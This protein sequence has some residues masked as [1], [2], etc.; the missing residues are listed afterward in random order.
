MKLKNTFLALVVAFAVAAPL[1][2]CTGYMNPYARG[3]PQPVGDGYN[4]WPDPD[5]YTP[6]PTPT[7]VQRGSSSSV[8]GTWDVIDM[9]MDNFSLGE[10]VEW[11]DSCTMEFSSNGSLEMRAELFGYSDSEYGTW[12][13]SGSKIDISLSGVYT[14]CD[15]RISGSKMSINHC[16]DGTVLELKRR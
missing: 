8:V 15:Y 13:V 14:T 7:P 5:P 4:D 16:D 11:L 12:S 1:T 9:G 3:Y 10:M 2:A 6:A